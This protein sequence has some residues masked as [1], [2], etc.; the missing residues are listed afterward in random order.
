MSLKP[1]DSNTINTLNKGSQGLAPRMVYIPTT[2]SLST[3]EDLLELMRS[4]PNV[5]VVFETSQISLNH[6]LSSITQ[7]QSYL[8]CLFISFVLPPFCVLHS[9]SSQQPIT[10]SALS[11]NTLIILTHQLSPQQT[12]P[13]EEIFF[14]NLHFSFHSYLHPTVPQAHSFIS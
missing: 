2:V 3:T 13:Y 1:K 11:H 7:S 8:Y 12:F 9:P 10:P 6:R 5:V 14:R 4:K